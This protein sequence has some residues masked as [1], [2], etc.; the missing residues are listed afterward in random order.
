MRIMQS[1]GWVTVILKCI[2][3]I[4]IPGWAKAYYRRYTSYGT[5]D[6]L[7]N[8]MTGGHAD[9]AHRWAT[10]CMDGEAMVGVHDGGDYGGLGNIWCKFM[11]PK[12]KP[13]FGIYP[14][15]DFCNVRNLDVMHEYY[16]YDKYYPMDTYDTFVTGFNPTVGYFYA[17]TLGTPLN[18]ALTDLNAGNLRNDNLY[19][20][21][22]LPHGYHLDYSRC[23]Y[24][25]THDKFGEH[26]DENTMFM[27]KCDRD[28]VMTGIGRG[29]NPWTA[30]LNFVWVQCCPL[31][32]DPT[33]IPL[34]A[35][36]NET[37]H[38]QAGAPPLR[39]IRR[40]AYGYATTT[41]TPAM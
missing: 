11:F 24:R 37:Y 2:I 21:C 4:I 6:T 27:G 32:Y 13:S 23:Q 28:A 16:C 29:E 26:Y 3:W 36:A 34:Y 9:D 7:I 38:W 8:V 33:F 1:F 10:E 5:G 30:G 14:Y 15:F 22:K 17:G 41:A 25:Y 40:P 19:K 18:P 39:Q 35:F 31:F 12:K 20:C